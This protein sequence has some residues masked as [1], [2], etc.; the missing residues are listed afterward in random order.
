MS[1]TVGEGT[2]PYSAIRVSV[3]VT[4]AKLPL[5]ALDSYR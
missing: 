1:V 4:S 3:T 5:G 2:P